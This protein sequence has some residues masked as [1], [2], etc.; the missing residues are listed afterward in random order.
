MACH[1]HREKRLKENQKNHTKNVSA[2]RALKR[3]HKQL[4]VL[5]KEKKINEVKPALNKLISAYAK[6][7]KRGILTKHKS[8][9]SIS[10]ITKKVNSLATA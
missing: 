10:N 5:I 8:S 9:R 1:R 4:L 2:K 7:A 3:A 6:M